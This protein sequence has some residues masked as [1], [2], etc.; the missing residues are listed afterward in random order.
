MNM[1]PENII[2][3]ADDFGFDHNRNEAIAYCIRSKIINSTTL[4]ANMDGLE[5]AL[6]LAATI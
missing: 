2:I 3:N 1:I 5:N 6:K 4:M